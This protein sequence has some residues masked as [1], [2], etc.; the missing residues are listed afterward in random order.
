MS[1]VNCT[2]SKHN[3]NVCLNSLN[4][5]PVIIEPHLGQKVGISRG[6]S[7]KTLQ[8]RSICKNIKKGSLYAYV[9]VIDERNNHIICWT[10]S[11]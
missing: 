1:F 5:A 6:L 8:G 9:L 11:S 2:Y 4:N 3:H 7:C 10:A